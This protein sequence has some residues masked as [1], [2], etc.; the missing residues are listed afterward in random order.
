MY[1][2]AHRVRSGKDV[3]G[4]NAFLHR[5]GQDAAWP[6]DPSAIPERDPG[7]QVWDA[8][9]VPP[10]GNDVLSYLD[11]IAPDG[12]GVEELDVALTGLWLDLQAAEQ[13]PPHPW[14]VLPNPLIY[15]RGRV[16]L[17]FGTVDRMA[18]ARA[19]ELGALRTALAPALAHPSLAGAA[20]AGTQRGLHSRS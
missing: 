10:G 1:A 15:R 12:V 8:V 13:D 3:E 6:A 14:A 2:T 7:Q 11:V 5:H 9:T 4:I 17:R 18:A 16:V 20:S 19:L